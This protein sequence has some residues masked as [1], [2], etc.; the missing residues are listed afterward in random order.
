M[1]QLRIIAAL[2]LTGFAFTTMAQ[3][4]DEAG[5]AFNEAIQHSKEKNHTEALKSYKTTIVIAEQLGEEGM[6]LKMK[7]ESQLAGV[8]FKM[9]RESYKA[10]EPDDAISHFTNSYEY[11]QLVNDEKAMEKAHRYLNYVYSYKGNVM[12]KKKDYTNAV[13]FFSRALE[14]KKDNPKTYY[15]L[16]VAQMREGNEDGMRN[17]VVNTIKHGE[18]GSKTVENAKEVAVK[19]Y[20]NAAMKAAQGKNF[21]EVVRVINESFKF[22]DKNPNAYY[23][24]ALAY[25]GMGKYDKA[26]EAASTGIE[27]NN[28]NP[29]NLYFLIGQAH[30]KKGEKRKACKNYA[31]VTQGNYVDAATYQMKTVLE[32]K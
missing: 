13:D 20:L 3:T 5:E 29:S 15:G 16:A 12:L 19:Y 26:I 21:P 8:F 28:K 2:I 7:A 6:D 10:K 27:A 22:D 32:C 4:L 31:K 14:Y 1:K 18:E 11:A 23:Y 25:N 30:E 24:L 17:A 9:G